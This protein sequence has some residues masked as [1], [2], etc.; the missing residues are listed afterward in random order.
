[1]TSRVAGRHTTVAEKLVLKSSV[2]N[3][4]KYLLYA[5]HVSE[6]INT[7]CTKYREEKYITKFDSRCDL[8]AADGILKYKVRRHI[9]SN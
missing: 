3:Q 6:A 4:I 7:K 2:S 8:R 5:E 9:G 1:M